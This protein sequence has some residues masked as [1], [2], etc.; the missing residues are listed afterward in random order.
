M[1]FLSG[2]DIQVRPVETAID[3][4]AQVQQSLNVECVD[5][6][7]ELPDLTVN[8]ISNNVPQQIKVKLPITINKFFE[9]T[10]MSSENFFQRWKN[11]NK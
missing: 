8:F 11:L 4:G 6:F 7:V 2:L 3:A 9:P 10:V 5:H 1:F